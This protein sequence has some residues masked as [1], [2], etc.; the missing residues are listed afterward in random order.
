M[1]GVLRGWDGRRLWE[2]TVCSR[3]WQWEG[4]GEWVGGKG[5]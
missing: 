4:L 5:C 1:A 2:G 3:G